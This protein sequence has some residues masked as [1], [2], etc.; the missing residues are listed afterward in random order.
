M[1]A[2][3]MN[4]S[5][6]DMMAVS[7]R[8][9]HKQTHP[10]PNGR[11]TKVAPQKLHDRARELFEEELIERKWTDQESWEATERAM[12]ELIMQD[13]RSTVTLSNC[14]CDSPDCSTARFHRCLLLA[15]D[16]L[17]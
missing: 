13:G 4:Q 3:Q 7:T 6:R 1:N 5:I 12:M 8:G 11:V 14:C 2:E 17:A 9:C 16:E 10:A 15:L